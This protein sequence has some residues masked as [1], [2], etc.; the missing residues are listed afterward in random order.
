MDANFREACAACLLSGRPLRWRG[1]TLPKSSRQPGAAG[2]FV[3][4]P[5]HIQ[6]APQRRL[7]PASSAWANPRL[8]VSLTRRGRTPSSSSTARITSRSCS[9]RT[10][11]WRSVPRP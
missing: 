7:S 3:V 11:R 9:D 8:V 2:G 1:A 6:S 10:A 4:G 5:Q